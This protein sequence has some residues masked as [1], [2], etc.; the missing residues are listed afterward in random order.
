M[1]ILK[2]LKACIEVKGQALTEYDDDSDEVAPPDSVTKYIAAV[3]GA[4]F[5]VR[6]GVEDKSLAGCEGIAFDL[7]LDGQCL[8]NV[9]YKKENWSRS[10]WQDGVIKRVKPNSNSWC[11][12]KFMFSELNLSE[13]SSMA[14]NFS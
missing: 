9:V 14:P 2:E 12:Q 11:I 10:T 4:E 7:Y 3:S 8:T 13:S 5:V 6:C 1:A